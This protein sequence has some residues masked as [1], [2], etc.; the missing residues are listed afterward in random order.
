MMTQERHLNISLLRFLGYKTLDYVDSPTLSRS[1]ELILLIYSHENPPGVL[2][3]VLG[4]S[5]QEGHGGVGTGLEEGH[6]DDQR[7]GA[8][9]LW[10]QGEGAGA[11]QP[12]EEKT[13]EGP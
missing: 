11:L 8:P 2:H 1:G 12:G 9:P 4:P 6:K 13:L 5:I 3:S 7:A 10:G